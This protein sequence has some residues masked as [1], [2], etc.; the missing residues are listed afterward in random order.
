VKCIKLISHNIFCAFKLWWLL[1]KHII[2]IMELLMLMLETFSYL[3]FDRHFHHHP[4][5]SH[6]Q[7]VI[8]CVCVLV[9][10][11]AISIAR[12]LLT[13]DR[14]HFNFIAGVE[15]EL[16]TLLLLIIW[17]G[18]WLLGWQSRKWYNDLIQG[19]FLS[20]LW[21]NSSTPVH[22]GSPFGKVSA[23]VRESVSLKERV[24]CWKCYYYIRGW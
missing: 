24:E 3:H 11:P 16:C 5:F 8:M 12:P 14:L 13:G 20:Y 2:I 10:L 6:W 18:Y 23:Y 15:L 19:S 4:L 7:G 22:H 1:L 9:W 21:I 17:N